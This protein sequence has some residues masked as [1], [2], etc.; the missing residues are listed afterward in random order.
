MPKTLRKNK[1]Q[2]L[3]VRTQGPSGRLRTGCGGRGDYSSNH[4]RPYILRPIVPEQRPDTRAERTGNGPGCH[5]GQR[6]GPR[7]KR[8][9]SNGRCSASHTPTVTSPGLSP[10]AAAAAATGNAASV[11]VFLPLTATKL[12]AAERAELCHAG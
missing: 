9:R 2:E 4:R 11:T 7:R 8:L 10:R 5:R 6:R 3:Y 12:G 1:M